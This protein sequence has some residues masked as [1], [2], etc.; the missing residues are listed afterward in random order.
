MI[1]ASDLQLANN[2]FHR[3]PHEVQD[4]VLFYLRT[5]GYADTWTQRDAVANILLKRI[6]KGPI[7]HRDLCVI[8]ERDFN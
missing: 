7:H 4:F 5:A 6:A 1:D 3:L 8:V 2:P